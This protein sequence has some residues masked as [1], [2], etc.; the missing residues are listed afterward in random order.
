MPV[1]VAQPKLRKCKNC[2]KSLCLIRFRLSNGRRLWQC[3][4]CEMERDTERKH[5]A[6]TILARPGTPTL[7]Q[8]WPKVTA[9]LGAAR[10]QTWIGEQAK[11]ACLLLELRDCGAG[12]LSGI[13]WR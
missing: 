13:L 12:A 2:M 6:G 11:L 8:V 7:C 1:D 9:Y 5:K 4:R 3:R 10:C